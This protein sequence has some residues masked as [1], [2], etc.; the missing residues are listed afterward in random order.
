M[1]AEL[2]RLRDL[3]KFIRSKNAGPFRVTFDVVFESSQ[4]F[5]HVRSSNA[6]T[7]GSVATAFGIPES[8]ISSLYEV[9][10]ALAYKITL[11]RPVVQGAMGET[12]VY[13][14][15]QHVPLMDLPVAAPGSAEKGAN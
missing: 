15:Q 12:D 9:P 2:V 6:I 4:A 10:M 13:G 1:T 8:Q 7:H 5:D 14:C 11:F 3:A